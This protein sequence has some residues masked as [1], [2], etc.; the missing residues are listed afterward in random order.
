MITKN[1]VQAL[2]NIIEYHQYLID[3]NYFLEFYSIFD[4]IFVY[5]QN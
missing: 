1:I 2:E 5:K 3:L 4:R